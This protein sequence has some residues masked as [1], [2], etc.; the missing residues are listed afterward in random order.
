MIEKL[1]HILLL[2]LLL[3]TAPAFGADTI[4]PFSSD[5]CSLFPDGT[6]N[7]RNKWCDCCFQ[8][9]LGYWRGGSEK[10]RRAADAALK[11]CVQNRT[12]DESLAETMYLGVRTGGHPAFPTWYRWGYG[13][14]YGRGYQPLSAE[15]KTQVKRR[16]SAYMAQHPQGYCQEERM[17]ERQWLQKIGVRR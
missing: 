1:L 3:T 4:R 16:L 17:R 10:E 2:A 14:K 9:D 13:W 7:D 6:L 5:G 8:H 12:G 15:E 11:A